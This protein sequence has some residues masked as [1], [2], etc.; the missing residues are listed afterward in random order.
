MKTLFLIIFVSSISYAT[1]QDIAKSEVPSQVSSALTSKF[2]KAKDIEWEMEGDLFKADFEVN[3]RDHELWIDRSGSIRRHREELS[4]RDLPQVITEKVKTEFQEY[5]IDD[6]HK[7]EDNGKI[8]Y[9]I[10]LD[11][12]DEDREV[13]FAE[14]GTIEQGLE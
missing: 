12:P 11:G 10:D 5:R 1:A 9:H 8:L 13:W 2:A 14:D 3:S 4:R 6:A 7:V